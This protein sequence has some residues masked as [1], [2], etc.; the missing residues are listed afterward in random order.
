MK[1]KS[2]Y[3]PSH[4]YWPIIGSFGLFF[5]V[6]GIVNILHNHSYGWAVF[7]SG[8]LLLTF[9]LFGWFSA[10]IS[11]PCLSWVRNI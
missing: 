2:Y 7:F 1:S 6:L 10:V 4:S 3:V 8:A 11:D 5:T 9:M